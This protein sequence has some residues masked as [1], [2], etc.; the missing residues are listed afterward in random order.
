MKKEVEVPVEGIVVGT[1]IP[2][3]PVGN[4]QAD[5][6]KVVANE[7]TVKALA[8]IVPEELT[9]LFQSE[10]AQAIANARAEVHRE[11]GLAG[12]VNK[13]IG[14]GQ[15]PRM[16]QEQQ[17]EWL[18]CALGSMLGRPDI[19]KP[20][21]SLDVDGLITQTLTV[22]AGTSGAYLVPDEFVAEIEKKALEP[23]VLWPLVQKRRTLRSSVT[24]P[25]VTT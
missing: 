1:Q 12:A 4:G 10:L 9:R 11:A 19:A 6:H 21:E 16:D 8:K 3:I 5:D 7:Q 22:T 14:R 2:P 25:E 24:K 23:A 20:S 15:R 18:R 17:A 13:T